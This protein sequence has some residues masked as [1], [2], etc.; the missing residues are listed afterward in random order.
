[1][2]AADEHAGGRGGAGPRSLKIIAADVADFW[3]FLER[4]GA[5]YAAPQGRA[6]WLE[7]R[8]CRI[9]VKHIVDFQIHLE[10]ARRPIDTWTMMGPPD[11][12]MD[13]L[14]GTA[15]SGI[16]RRG[17]SARTALVAARRPQPRQ[18]CRPARHPSPRLLN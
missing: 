14:C 16:S 3:L 13:G 12:I 18:S 6:K 5:A 17:S 2:I 15:R 7:D 4:S 1:L 8:R 9:A 10:T 11:Q